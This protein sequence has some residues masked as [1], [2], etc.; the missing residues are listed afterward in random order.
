MPKTYD[1][2]QNTALIC[3]SR[4]SFHKGENALVKTFYCG[5][6]HSTPALS[7]EGITG[8]H[9]DPRSVK[10]YPGSTIVPYSINIDKS[11]SRDGTTGMV[12]GIYLKE[13]TACTLDD[14][15]D[16]IECKPSKE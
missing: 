5:I 4:P 6:A 2:K 9:V 15:K 14:V 3:E 13:G 7:E 11:R 12:V 8:I 10:H 16:T 1:I